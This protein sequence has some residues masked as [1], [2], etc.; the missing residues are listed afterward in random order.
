MDHH[1]LRESESVFFPRNG[2]LAFF[3]EL[4]S[5]LTCPFEFVNVSDVRSPPAQV[6]YLSSVGSGA[7]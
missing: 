2:T 6:P 1:M 7:P 5:L 4:S 3:V